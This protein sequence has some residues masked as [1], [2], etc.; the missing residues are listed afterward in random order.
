[1]DTYASGQ[2]EFLALIL[3]SIFVPFGIYFYLLRESVVSRKIVLKFGFL[4]IFVAGID[5]F[6]LQRL[7][8]ISRLAA[9]LSNDQFFASEVAMALYL[10]PAL[11]AGIGINVVSHILIRHLTEAE[12][13]FD[14]LRKSEADAA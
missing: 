9:T 2:V 11:F 6:L 13:R 1:M 10:L 4:L 3:F 8:E 7:R 5:V 12:N 14:Q